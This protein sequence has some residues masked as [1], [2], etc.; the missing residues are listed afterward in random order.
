MAEGAA[1]R[2]SH[3]ELCG[4]SSTMGSL[5][6]GVRLLQ[7]SQGLNEAI[8]QEAFHKHPMSQAWLSRCF[9]TAGLRT[10]VTTELMK[11][12]SYADSTRIG[13]PE[14][15]IIKPKPARNSKL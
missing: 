12:L 5:C 9:G 2:G 3:P 1:K 8:C 6:R 13:T 4:S 10:P 11:A 14:T 7:A 15:Q